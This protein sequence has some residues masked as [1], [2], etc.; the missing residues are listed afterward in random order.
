MQ[1]GAS[2]GTLPF[3]EQFFVGGAETLRGYR[4]DRF[5]GQYN[6]LG[7]IEL[8]QPL[9]RRLKGVLFLDAGDAWGGRYNKV[10][11]EGFEQAGFKTRCRYRAG[12][13]RRHAARADPTGL[14]FWR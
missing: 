11:I 5:W 14:R 13:P 6:L 7:S 1:F 9:A 12:H 10:N 3:F 8:R 4:E 2:T